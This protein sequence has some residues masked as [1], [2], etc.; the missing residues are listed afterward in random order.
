M[1]EPQ[2]NPVGRPT[3]YDPAMCKEVVRWMGMGYSKE[4]T[5]AALNIGKTSFFKYIDEFPEFANA[6][7]EGESRNLLFWEGAGL[8]GMYA[9]K[10]SAP[11][12]IFNMKNR[13]KWSDRQEITGDPERPQ[14]VQHHV[15]VDAVGLDE[16]AEKFGKARG[17]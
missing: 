15:T 7:R 16:L 6:V 3:K 1:D 4:A 13:F 12:W 2:N 11:V 5:A 10:F 9:E 14:Q 8:S 17:A